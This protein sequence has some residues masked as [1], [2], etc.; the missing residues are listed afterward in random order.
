M[1]IGNLMPS[2]K[3]IPVPTLAA[4]FEG[5]GPVEVLDGARSLATAHRDHVREFHFHR[6]PAFPSMAAEAHPEEYL[7]PASL[8]LQP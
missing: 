5:F 3:A 6:D 1:W 8:R 2:S 4:R 7:V